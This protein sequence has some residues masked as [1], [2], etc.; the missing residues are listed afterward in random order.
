MY[1][2][3]LCEIESELGLADFHIWLDPDIRKPVYH[4]VLCASLTPQPGHTLPHGE[5]RSLV[6]DSQGQPAGMLIAAGFG[7]EGVEYV[8]PCG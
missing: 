8:P 4:E 1:V 2:T 6:V 3:I 7:Q 5:G